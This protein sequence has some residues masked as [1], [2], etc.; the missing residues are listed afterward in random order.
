MQTTANTVLDVFIRE[1]EQILTRQE[2]NLDWANDLVKFAKALK[3]LLKCDYALSQSQGDQIINVIQFM[4]HE[5]N[6]R[7]SLGL[8]QMATYIHSLEAVKPE[9]KGPHFMD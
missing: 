8:F 4:I 7:R 6:Y 2:K 3:E 9:I 1:H 5:D